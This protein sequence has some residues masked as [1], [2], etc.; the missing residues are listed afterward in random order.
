MTADYINVSNWQLV[1]AAVLILINVAI[2]VWLRQGLARTL[3]VASARMVVQLLLV[4]FI[5][6]SVFELKTP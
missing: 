1:F 3:L 5:L 2:S 4:G 6:Q